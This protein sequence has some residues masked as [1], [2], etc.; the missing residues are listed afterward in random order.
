MPT[1][2]DMRAKIEQLVQEEE[3]LPA[4]KKQAAREAK[5]A[6]IPPTEIAY[7][8]K[9]TAATIYNWLKDEK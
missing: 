1:A 5:H 7:R 2:D 9:V 6:G 3:A 4:R 8:F